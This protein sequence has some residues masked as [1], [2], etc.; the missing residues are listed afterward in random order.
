MKTKILLVILLTA[1]VPGL[2][3]LNAQSLQVAPELKELIELSINKDQKVNETNIDRQ[4]AEVQMKAVQS[5]YL[6]KIELGGKYLYAQSMLESKI[7]EITGF[8]SL[9]SLQEM[10]KNPAFP[11]M[12]PNL[13]QLSSEISNLQKLMAQQGV[14]FPS[15]T[16]D[17]GGSLY[18]NYVGIDATAKM[19]IYSGG[20]VPNTAK[21]LSAKIK[22]Q[23]ALSEKCKTDVIGDV[24]TCYDQLAL[25]IQSGQ[26]LDESSG[27]LAAE[28]RYAVSALNNGM[29]TSFDTLK[30][31]VAEANLQ[32]RKSEYESKRTLLFQKL[33]QLTGKPAT[34]F[35]E[36][37]PELKIM[38][39]LD[40]GAGI[41][42]RAELKALSEGVEA[43]K[44]MLKSE[45]STY[46]PKVQAFA[47]ARYDYLFKADANFNAP[48][49]TDM[50]FDNLGL[51]PTLVV[52]AGFKWEIFDKSG[53]SSKVRQATL[54]VK[55]AENARDE[56]RELLELNQV[57]AVSIYN[58]ALSQVEYKEKQ[59]QAAHRALDLAGKSYDEGMINITERLAA[60]TEMQN[61]EFEF[62]QA[63]YSQR[64]AAIE[65]YKATGDLDLQNIK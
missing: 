38:V 10:M 44:Y 52:G 47:S 20:Q 21:A 14:S 65:C 45:K 22:A 23:E 25:L 49:A 19:L 27:R 7:N 2:N 37:H 28:K 54:E 15:L 17:L 30:I 26:V 5:S 41:S 24:I 51:G 1:F 64:Q 40:N 57:R 59:R 8:E 58:A 36:L 9:S 39:H 32:A 31:A 18:G 35:E 6:P 53:G 12:F 55:K 16:Q 33:A 4:I 63:V 34:Y 48:M 29:A 50:K 62:L 3:R 56:A 42:N 61:T 46:L 13:A 11:V 60:E 43:R